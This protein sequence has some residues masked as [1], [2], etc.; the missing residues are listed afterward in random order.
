MIRDG[1]YVYIFVET[2]LSVNYLG[3][4]QTKFNILDLRLRSLHAVRPWD[5]F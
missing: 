3:V 4:I 1:I 5:E 2:E